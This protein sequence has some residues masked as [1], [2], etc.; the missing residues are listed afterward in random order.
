MRILSAVLFSIGLL[1]AMAFSAGAVWADLEAS[2][3]E[4]SRIADEPL[5]TLRCPLVITSQESGTIAATFTNP[6]ERALRRTVRAYITHGFSS[7]MR[8][9]DTQFMLEP[10]ETH[11]LEWT[12]TA[13]DAAWRRFVLVRVNVLRNFP[14][15]SRSGSCG[16][17]VMN[18]PGLNGNQIVALSFAAIL[19]SMG[20][21]VAIWSAANKSSPGRIP[22]LTR[23]MAFLAAIVVASMLFSLLGWWVPGG[24]LLVLA[25]IVTVSMVTWAVTRAT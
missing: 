6:S 14:L 20:A 3:F 4:P 21:G 13:D 22:D 18:L 25:L 19:L 16:V 2:L 24:L 15:P 9:V 23:A 1:L 8:E 11:R 5:K 10:G 12:V 17:L 7:L